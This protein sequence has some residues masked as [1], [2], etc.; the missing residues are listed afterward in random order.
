MTE[1]APKPPIHYDN[2][3]IHIAI[4]RQKQTRHDY[5][6]ITPYLSRQHGM[7]LPYCYLIRY[8]TLLPYIVN[9]SC[10]LT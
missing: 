2:L 9:P 10:Y 5:L 4:P 1:P 6:L 3:P 7:S 8:F